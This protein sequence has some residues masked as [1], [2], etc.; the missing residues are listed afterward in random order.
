MKYLA[1]LTTWLLLA[2]CASASS[3]EQSLL[4][5]D[6]EE[7]SHQA[8]IARGIDVINEANKR[9]R[10]DRLKT[11]IFSRA[12]FDGTLVTSNGGAVRANHRWYKLSF[13]CSVTKDQMKA[14]SFDYRLGNEIPK[15]EWE[16]LGLW[17]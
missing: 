12:K 1:A 11:S 2:Q 17:E 16:D 7:R 14:V 8:C 15:N 6:P 5:L 13:T 3:L 9:L 4:K 10:V